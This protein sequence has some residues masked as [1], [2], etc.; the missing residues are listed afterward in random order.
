MAVLHEKGA[1][2]S[3]SDPFVPTL[4]G[5]GWPGGY[6]LH[7]TPLDPATVASFDC[8]AILTDHRVVDYKTL[9]AAAPLIVDTRNTI[10]QSH[11]HV[12]RLGAPRPAERAEAAESEPLSA[13][14]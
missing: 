1:R 14:A 8:I 12:Y 7:S 9:V 2:V 13:T 5:R 4:S 3:Y 11:P 6:A 10:K